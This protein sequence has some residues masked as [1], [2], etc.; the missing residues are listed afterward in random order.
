MVPFKTT[1]LNVSANAVIGN[2]LTVTGNISASNIVYAL[3][4]NSSLWNTAYTT[5][6]SNSASWGTG[7]GGGVTEEFV[8]AMSIGLS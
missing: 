5:V 7:G 6:Q 2:G 1:S 8:V 3:S 4:G